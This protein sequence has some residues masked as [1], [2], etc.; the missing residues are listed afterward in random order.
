MQTI[1]RLTIL[2]G[3]GVVGYWLWKEGGEVKEW[4][5]DVID[6]AKEKSPLN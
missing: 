4:L 2:A 5:K 3:Y 6:M 1:A